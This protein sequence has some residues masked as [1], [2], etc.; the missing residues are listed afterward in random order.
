MGLIQQIGGG[1]RRYS[2]LPVAPHD[3]RDAVEL[4]ARKSGRT[5]T[6]H[7][8]PF[9]GW[10]VRFNLRSNDS[11]MLLWKNGTAP[12][13]P[14][15][16]VWLHRENPRF[17]KFIPGTNMEREP[18]YLPY[19]LHE[20]GVTGV[21]EILERGNTFSKRGEH[22]SLESAVKQAGESNLAM[23][24]K[25]RADQKEASRLESREKRRSILKIPFLPGGLTMRK[26]KEKQA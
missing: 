18:R 23:K 22:D 24:R 11:R 12:E 5:G 16:D 25:N 4:Y 26:K 21:V 6:I 3:I 20:L 13:P 14:S 7:F 2:A 9:G 15:E 10:F 8:V 1:G 19:Q 17:G